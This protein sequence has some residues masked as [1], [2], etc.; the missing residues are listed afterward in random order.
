MTTKKKA[1]GE[2]IIMIVLAIPVLATLYVIGSSIYEP[3]A[4]DQQK[5]LRYEKCLFYAGQDNKSFDNAEFDCGEEIYGP[6][7]DWMM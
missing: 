1:S 7:N 4:E 2:W 6:S 5:K 3:S